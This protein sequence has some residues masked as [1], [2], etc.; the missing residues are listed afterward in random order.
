MAGQEQGERRGLEEKSISRRV[1]LPY[2][3]INGELYV[4]LL[5]EERKLYAPLTS[6]NPN[7]T[8]FQFKKITK[9]RIPFW[10]RQESKGIQP[11]KIEPS[12]LK[13]ETMTI[14]PALEVSR[15]FG[16]IEA[17]K[18]EFKGDLMRKVGSAAYWENDIYEI[19]TDVL[20]PV[21]FEAKFIT[22]C[23]FYHY[24]KVFNVSDIVTLAGFARLVNEE[25]FPR[26]RNE[27]PT[28]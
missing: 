10:R 24:S 22:K 25:L 13:G 2:T 26:L 21:S 7:E 12:I 14:N 6:I 5:Q 20:I 11:Y 4:G 16:N 19:N 23:R 9:H 8:H 27:N 28:L 17:Y 3:I 15:D 18:L 1:T